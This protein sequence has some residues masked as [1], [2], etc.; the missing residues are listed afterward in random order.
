MP[1]GN[2]STP[3]VPKSMPAILKS[4]PAVPKSMP[5][6]PKMVLA[7]SKSTPERPKL[8][9]EK[10][11]SMSGGLKSTPAQS[12]CNSLSANQYSPKQKRPGRPRKVYEPCSDDDV[13]VVEMLEVEQ[14]TKLGRPHGTVE[15][16]HS[17]SGRAVGRLES[18]VSPTQSVS[19][20]QTAVQLPKGRRGRVG[21]PKKVMEPSSDDDVQIVEP[22]TIQPKPMT[23]QPK[24]VK[25]KPVSKSPGD[26]K[27]F[28]ISLLNNLLNCPDQYSLNYMC[29]FSDYAEFSVLKDLWHKY[30]IM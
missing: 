21:R 1:A 29:N 6:V 24:P 19:V 14:P 26:Q 25:V 11:K 20:G 2:K 10:L 27:S 22:M 12:S 18:A 16:K 30:Q 28:G 7:G 17:G 3:A 4:T 23:I 9:P 5:A 15:R 8:T 13:Q